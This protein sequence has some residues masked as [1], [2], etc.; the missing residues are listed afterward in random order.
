M[1]EQ[2]I[3]SILFYFFAGTAVLASLLILF[4]KNIIHSAFL[5][6]L[7]FLCVAGVYVLMRADFLAIAQIMIY[8]GGILVLMIF[9]IMLSSRLDGKR[10]YTQSRNRF[11]GIA[12]A[13][14]LFYLMVR[15]V[16]IADFANADW[17]RE[18]PIR[19][20]E[21]MKDG[22]L[23]EIGRLLMSDYVMPFELAGIV[24]L[25]ALVGA[26]LIASFSKKE[27]KS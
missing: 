3:I 1:S 13:G 15:V 14:M 9:G 2:L 22:S 19:S 21:L 6:V 5:L 25:V 18:A 11:L 26:S 4:K 16:R 20:G 12:V 10:L 24:L 7:V 8:I 27:V 23:H 17:I